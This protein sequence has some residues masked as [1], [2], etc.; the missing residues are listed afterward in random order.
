MGP[1]REAA[2]DSPPGEQMKQRALLRRDPGHARPPSR[3]P[4]FPAR[5]GAAL[6]TAK[7]RNSRP[8]DRFARH[9]ACAAVT[10]CRR[11]A[12]R[13]ERANHEAGGG[14]RGESDD[15]RGAPRDAIGWP[16]EA[17]GGEEES[18]AGWG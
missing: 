17:G 14:A 8:R 12:P 11:R 1:R 16:G 15:A 13:A 9:C 5:R 6:P 7:L 4:S 2:H 18:W 3:P 10:R